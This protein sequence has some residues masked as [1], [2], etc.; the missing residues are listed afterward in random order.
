M[1]NYLNLTENGNEPDHQESDFNHFEQDEEP[2]DWFTLDKKM[3]ELC[4]LIKD[5]RFILDRM[6][7]ELAQTENYKKIPEMEENEICTSFNCFAN[8]FGEL[9]IQNM[10]SF[11]RHINS[12]SEYM[13]GAQLANYLKDAQL[14]SN[15]KYYTAANHVFDVLVLGDN[16][17]NLMNQKRIRDRFA[18]YLLMNDMA[19][20]ELIRRL[21]RNIC[22]GEFE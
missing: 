6:M 8:T 14:S 17:F 4:Q 11:P 7:T 5:D 12:I 21:H 1:T 9:G 22:K 19:T 15:A 13:T 18:Q 10:S 20:V 2:V 3:D 16:I